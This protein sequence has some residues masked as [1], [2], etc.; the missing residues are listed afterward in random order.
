MNVLEHDETFRYQLLSRMQMDCDYYLGNGQ[1]CDK[2][3][4]ESNVESQVKTMKEIYNSF[5]DDKKPQ[6]LSWEEIEEYERKML[7][8]TH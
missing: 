3:L 4:W 7:A 5:D 8:S 6:W 2:H 1:F